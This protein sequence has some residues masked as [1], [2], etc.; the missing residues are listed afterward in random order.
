VIKARFGDRIDGWIEAALPFLFQRRI[1][2]NF[3][4]LLGLLISLVAS[5]AFA[6]GW[7]RAGGVLI[8]VG[9]FFDLVD[10]VVARHHGMSSTFGAFLDSTLD[11]LVDML[12]LLGI[13]MHY[14]V[15]DRPGEVLLAG[16]VLVASVMTS[17]TKARAERFV[18]E[19]GGGVLERGER[20]GLLAAGAILGFLVLALWVV[21]I[22]ATVTVIQRF[23]LARREMERLDAA[24]RA[25]AAE[26]GG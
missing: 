10:G 11:R 8:L 12:L 2:P 6:A 20:V 15:V 16:V 21:A 9:G 23:L 7:L 13:L 25:G 17:Y 5:I 14:A 1:D 19:F 22:G 4:T 18:P 26:Q 24:A 3:L